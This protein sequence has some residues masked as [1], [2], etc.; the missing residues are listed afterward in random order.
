MY[1]QSFSNHEFTQA[2]LD[3]EYESCTFTNCRF[4]GLN[5]SNIQFIDCDFQ[6]C[7]LSG[8]KLLQTGFKN[9][10]FHTCKLLGLHFESCNPFLLELSF[11]HCNLQLS[12]FYK[13]KLKGTS[14]LHSQLH[15]VDFTEADL[16]LANFS[17]S[18]LSQA[19]FDQTQ[20]QEADFR[21]AHSYR[22]HP[23]TNSIKKA[24]FSMPQATGL[25]LDFGIQLC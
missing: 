5:L 11:T 4:E 13:L 23:L 8:A 20:L 21:E 9:V 14:F 3:K 18:D 7:N 22:I 17:G 15:E 24:K 10:R 1:N 19:V 16:S 12:C 25:L 2:E 6:G